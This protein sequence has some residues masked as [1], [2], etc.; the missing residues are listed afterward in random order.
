MPSP[1]YKIMN[2]SLTVKTFPENM[3]NQSWTGQNS[4][5]LGCTS[6]TILELQLFVYVQ[7]AMCF[8]LDTEIG[9]GGACLCVDNYMS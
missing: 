4:R 2:V 7:R 1:L 6:V 8:E 9:Y 3:M 5:L